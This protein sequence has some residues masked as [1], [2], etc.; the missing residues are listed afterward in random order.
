MRLALRPSHSP[1][2]F[3]SFFLFKP[4]DRAESLLYLPTN[5]WNLVPEP[6]PN[7]HLIFSLG[8]FMVFGEVKS[9]HVFRKAV[10]CSTGR[11]GKS[12]C[13]RDLLAWRMS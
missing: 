3:L 4:K 6:S 13:N 7:F 1:T 11:S 2:N 12:Y 10:C 8:V 5:R 9:A